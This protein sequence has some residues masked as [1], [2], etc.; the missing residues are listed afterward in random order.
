MTPQLFPQGLRVNADA[1]AYVETLQTTDVKQSWVDR[2]ADEG[3]LQIFQQV[4]EAA[5]MSLCPYDPKSISVMSEH[6]NKFSPFY[7]RPVSLKVTHINCPTIS[8]HDTHG[9]YTSLSSPLFLISFLL[10]S[11]SWFVQCILAE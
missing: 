1:D 8:T 7:N 9:S 5:A 11:S 6:V 10:D 3:G 2:G 4:R